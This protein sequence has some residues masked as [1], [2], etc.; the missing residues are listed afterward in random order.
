MK[1]FLMRHKLEKGQMI[2]IVVLMMLAIMGMVALLIDGGFLMS[3][4]R[5]A[6]AAADAGAL[7][8]AQRICNGKPDAKAAAEYYASINSHVTSVFATVSEHFVTVNATVEHPSFFANIFGEDTLTASAKATA[9]CL[10][11]SSLK[12]VLPISFFYASPPVDKSVDCSDLSNPCDLVAWDF[13]ELM[14][15]L[16]SASINHLPLEKIYIV[17]DNTKICQQDVVGE[18][19]CYDLKKG[20]DGGS[21]TWIDLSPLKDPPANI[22][23]IITSGLDRPLI[24]NPPIWVNSEEGTVSAGYRDLFDLPRIDGYSHLD[25]R[26]VY[27]PL[28]DKFCTSDPAV[29]CADPGDQYIDGFKTNSRSYRLRGLSAFVV[30]CVTRNARCYAGVCVPQNDPRNNTNSPQCPG[31]LTAE[32]SDNHAIEGYFVTGLK[33]EGLSG[34]GGVD[35]GIYII[36][37]TE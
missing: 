19:I 36:S 3:N 16:G 11:P 34:S 33:P 5:Y 24:V 17:S 26:L 6:Q 12:N 15:A 32:D 1:Y 27:V 7:A 29:N 9:G 21:R 8:G 23:N 30:T 25:V 13:E 18:I 31:Y 2:P 4:R 14:G 35:G 37:L 28:F 20:A 22:N 10:S